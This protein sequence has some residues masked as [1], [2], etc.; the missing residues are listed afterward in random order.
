MQPSAGTCLFARKRIWGTAGRGFQSGSP[1]FEATPCVS[2][3][4]RLHVTACVRGARRSPKELAAHACEEPIIG[5]RVLVVDD[6]QMVA[7]CIGD[8]PELL[9]AKSG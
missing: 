1:P 7:T 9:G 2:D 8:S 4:N 5:H 6:N 3:A